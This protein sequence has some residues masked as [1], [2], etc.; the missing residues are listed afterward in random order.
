MEG[1]RDIHRQISVREDYQERS[2]TR[3]KFQGQPSRWVERAKSLLR[4]EVKPG[5]M[6]EVQ[7]LEL[8]HHEI[9]RMTNVM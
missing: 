4:E 2:K 6:A 7:F 1:G 3:D 5:K 8:Q 9:A